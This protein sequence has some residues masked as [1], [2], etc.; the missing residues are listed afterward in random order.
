ML[1]VRGGAPETEAA[2]HP[3]RMAESRSTFQAAEAV[4]RIFLSILAAALSM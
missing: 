4:L 1:Y 3:E 2:A